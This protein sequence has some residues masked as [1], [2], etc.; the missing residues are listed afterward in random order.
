MPSLPVRDSLAN[1]LHFAKRAPLA[2]YRRSIASR[3]LDQHPSLKRTYELP[4][5]N[6]VIDEISG[7][8][9]SLNVA[10]LTIDPSGY[11]RW[12]AAARY[13][14]LAYHA[15]AEEKFLE[16]YLSVELLG[17]RSRGT[18]VD[19]ASCRSFFPELMRRRGFDVIVQDLSYPEGLHGDRLGCDAANFS[20]PDASVDA[21]TLHC[22]FEHF[23]GDADSGFLRETARLLRPGGIAIIIP[24]Y[25]HTERII[26]V[27]PYFLAE[28]YE[29]E[30]P[31]TLQPAIGYGN[32]F[33]RM[34]DPPAFA[35]RVAA[36][37]AHTDLE[38]TLWRIDG[39]HSISARCYVQFALTVEKPAGNATQTP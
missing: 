24:L 16:H 29:I 38:P 8:V 23:E 28:G 33:G 13:P 37:I 19:V 32:R 20:L 30:E 1:T 27:D 5:Q 34:Y 26:W 6:A 35:E 15:M 7:L 12:V 4:D 25:L 39:A 18:F 10:R 11:E 14:L 2:L 36:T 22:S 17:T 3:Y 9:P 21:M 31:G